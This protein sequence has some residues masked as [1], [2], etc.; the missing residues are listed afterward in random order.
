LKV[1]LLADVNSIHT[2]RW[3]RS[4]SDQGIEIGIFSLNRPKSDTAKGLAGSSRPIPIFFPSGFNND[5][6]ASGLVSKL[7]YLTVIPSLRKA[8][9]EFNPDIVHA[10]YASSY[11]TLGS[12]SGFHPRIL[13]LWGSDIFDFPKRS[14]LTGNLL[15]F[16]LSRADKVLSTSHAMAAEAAKYTRKKIEIVPFGIDPEK[17]KPGIT[18]SLFGKDDFVIGTVKA[19]E[20]EYGI[21]YLIQS[22]ASLCGKFTEKSI[23]L[24]I[25]GDGS[26]AKSLRELADS[27]GFGHCICF[28]GKISHEDVPGYLNM[29]DVYAALSLSE[30]FG[31]A[32]IEAS[33]C[34]LPVVV[35]NIGGLKEVVKDGITGLMVP[36]ATTR[37]PA[38]A[39]EKLLSD[40][41]FRLKLGRN[42]RL[43]VE[44]M[45]NWRSN[46][47]EMIRIYRILLP[48]ILTRQ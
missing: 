21:E 14:I 19:L 37:E 3:A 10:H 8:I 4:L 28:T 11:G 23:R 12:L 47:D 31:V 29:M 45:Y 27:T 15:K 35:T 22:F 43:R 41:D 18:N 42:G 46:V 36:P 34:K 39:F 38:E 44:K 20:P 17:F 24:L 25:V 48:E 16:N 32:V 33:A 7:K 5:I 9:K 2:R 26:L 1:L 6:S 13:S 40:D 30:S